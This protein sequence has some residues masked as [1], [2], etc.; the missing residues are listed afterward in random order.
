MSCHIKLTGVT[1]DYTIYSVRAQS[2]RN[3]ALN[4]AIGGKLYKNQ[5]DIT[6]MRALSNI[7]LEAEEGDRLALVGHNG[8]GKTTLLRVIAGIYA[9]TKG[10]VEVKGDLASMLALGAGM[11]ADATGIQNIRKMGAMRMIPKRQI[12]DRIEAIAD[13]SDLGHFLQLPLKTYS[14]G[15]TARL[16]FSV[17]TEFAADILVMDEWLS[18]GDS[19]FVLKAT[20]RMQSFVQRAKILVIGT[21]DI[22]LVQRVCNKVCVLENGQP[23]YYGDVETWAARMGMQPLAASVAA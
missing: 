10:L 6:V 14:A 2:L 21:H 8:S 9:P 11:D 15:M 13:F 17:A 7:H 20:Q 12:E 3:L 19:N 18:A 16:M 22:G 23:I 4:M 1:L 5:G